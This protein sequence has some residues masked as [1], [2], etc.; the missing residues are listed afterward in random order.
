MP[1]KDLAD[2]VKDRCL[3]IDRNNDGHTNSLEELTQHL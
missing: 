3:R 2:V 1:R